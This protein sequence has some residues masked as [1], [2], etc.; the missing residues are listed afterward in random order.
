MT[1]LTIQV[2]RSPAY[3]KEQL[4]HCS[5]M[6]AVDICVNRVPGKGR[7]GLEEAILGVV[8]KRYFLAP[9]T[10]TASVTSRNR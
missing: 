5:I 6:V 7:E 9:E 8:Q 2:Q 3:V 10:K 1:S 4:G